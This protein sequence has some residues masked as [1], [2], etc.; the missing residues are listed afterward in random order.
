MHFYPH[1]AVII[2][3]GVIFF[4]GV[5]LS[6][7]QAQDSAAQINKYKPTLNV[8]LGSSIITFDSAQCSGN[9]CTVG[10]I[11]Q[12]INLLYRYGIGIAAILATVMVMVGGFFWL[13]SGG[14][15]DRISLGKEFITAAISGLV[16]ALFSYTI[17]NF[18][19][20]NLVNLKGLTVAAPKAVTPDEHKGYFRESMTPQEFFDRANSYGASTLP[21]VQQMALLKD[22]M[23][24]SAIN[25]F[26]VTPVGNNNPSGAVFNWTITPQNE[27]AA[28]Q[29]RRCFQSWGLDSSSGYF[30]ADNTEV[31]FVPDTYIIGARPTGNG[32]W[33]MTMNMQLQG[34]G[35]YLYSGLPL[36]GLEREVQL[37]LG[38]F[39]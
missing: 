14:S 20:P 12:Y 21:V 37:T 10:W 9:V 22:C 19:N 13:M 16:I 38:L 3:L 6:P 17:L 26:H 8:K 24:E 36:T 18:I 11:G 23:G 31:Q 5:F 29:A 39:R 34:L 28:V 1:K 4:L 33:E 7:V 25:D 15:P 2:S 32:S 35:E 27:A 30:S